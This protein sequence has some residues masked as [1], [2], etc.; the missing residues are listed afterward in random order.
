MRDNLKLYTVDADYIKYLQQDDILEPFI[1]DKKAGND[2]FARKYLGIVLTENGLNY[3]IPFS[4]PKESDYILNKDGIRKIRKNTLT[5]FRMTV[6]KRDGQ[7]EL[8]GTLKLNNMLPVPQSVLTEYII[9]NEVNAN[10]R[11][12]IQKEYT[13]IKQKYSVIQK[14]AQVLYKQKNNESGFGKDKPNYLNSTIPFEYAEKKF[15]DYC[16]MNNLQ[17]SEE[18]EGKD[19]KSLE[20]CLQEAKKSAVTTLELHQNRNHQNNMP[21]R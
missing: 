8:K 2:A 17:I 12:I 9:K 15:L 4:S 19:R 21:T 13:Y 7:L 14:N 20:Q 18:L 10:Y 11:D 16:K 3:F 1:I 6:T 5:I